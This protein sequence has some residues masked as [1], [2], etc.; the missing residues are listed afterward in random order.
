MGGEGCPVEATLRVIGGK[1][2]LLILRDLA[3]GPRRFSELQKSLGSVS[4]KCLS[5]RLKELERE[6]ILTRT[7]YPEVPPRVE[8]ALTEKGQALGSIIAAMREWG[9]RWGNTG[10]G[11][12]GKASGETV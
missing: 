12:G 4:P 5:D 7:V 1:W 11:S 10:A 6:G 9:L 3:E 8:Y 2:T